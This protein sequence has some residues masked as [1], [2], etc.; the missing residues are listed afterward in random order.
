M[1]TR[2]ARMAKIV[3]RVGALANW[4]IPL[5]AILHAWHGEDPRTI[6]PRMT[7]AL[8]VYSVLFM[9]WALAI[10]PPNYALLFCHASNEV[11]QLLQLGRWFNA[12]YREKKAVASTDATDSSSSH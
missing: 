5:A 9:R 12:T 4:G 1:A 8:C 3:G 6:D 2:K 7:S 10:Y 11:V